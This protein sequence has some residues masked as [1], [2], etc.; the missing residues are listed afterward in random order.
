MLRSLLAYLK[1]SVFR[2]KSLDACVE[3][4]KEQVNMFPHVT[5]KQGACASADCRFEEGVVLH[6]H[7]QVSMSSVGK[8]T[9]ISYNSVINNT[10]I[11]R[12][13]SVGP[14]V[15]AGLGRHPTKE[16]VSTYPAFYSTK[17]VGCL[18]TF[19]KENLYE[20]NEQISI[21]HDVWIGARVIIIDGVKIGNGAIIGAGSV[22]TKDVPDYAITGGVPATAIRYRFMPDE[23]E[24][25]LRLSWWNKDESWITEHV[26]YF[27]D[28]KLL[29]EKVRNK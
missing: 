8:R 22:V 2:G 4:G 21:G 29:M 11:G 13:C 27:Q 14:E 7:T 3:A 26:P 5:F 19:V 12:Y 25:L 17:N 16:F 1:T 23:I 28:I 9:Y 20:E 18:C 10:R 24:F 15:M 6:A